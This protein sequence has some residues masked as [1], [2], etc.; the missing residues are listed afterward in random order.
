VLE[1]HKYDVTA[2]AAFTELFLYDDTLGPTQFLVAP[3]TQAN[4]AAF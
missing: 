1:Q 4:M 3:D 2:P